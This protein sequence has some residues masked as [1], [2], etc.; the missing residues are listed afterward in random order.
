LSLFFVGNVMETQRAGDRSCYKR[1]NLKLQTNFRDLQNVVRSPITVPV[2]PG[3][4]TLS[5]SS[6]KA[7]TTR[8]SL[9]KDSQRV[10]VKLGTNV[11]CRENGELATS[12][13]YA[14]VEDLVDAH[15]SG[16]ELILVSS[17]SISLGMHRLGLGTQPES[18]AT[19]QA[20]AA[21]GQIQLMGTY[22][23]AFDRSG[24]TTAQLLLTESDF[25]NRG[26]YL[27]LRN[28]MQKLLQLGTIPIVNEND[29]VSTMEIETHLHEETDG[30]AVVFGDNDM[31]SALVA[32]KLG[33]DLLVILSN[34]DGLHDKDPNSCSDSKRLAT[35]TSITSEVESLAS[36][37]SP[38]GRGGM[39]TKI[40]A[41]RVATRSGTITIVA[42]GT[43]TGALSQILAGDDVGTCFLP[44]KAL[45]S[46]KRWIAFASSVTG[47]VR[48]NAGARDALLRKRAS[49]LFAGV[50]A[51]EKGFATGDIVSIVDDAGEEVARGIS[52]YSSDEASPLV[53]RKSAEISTLRPDQPLREELIHRDNIVIVSHENTGD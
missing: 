5:E 23:Q 40:Q 44:Q 46:R 3:M 32:S 14:L 24:I 30:S 15:R 36:G 28:T 42:R 9:V 16:K 18:L 45:S 34:V 51:L 49:L 13:L 25:S 1:Y 4:S 29:T 48:V 31:L 41:A 43:E 37:R 53:G 33:A 20:C 7:T 11:L 52:N 27:N 6:H 19:K 47:R 17:G 26:R 50:T 12:R 39:K 35:V 21:I 38:L 22:E 10:V 2:I 8:Q